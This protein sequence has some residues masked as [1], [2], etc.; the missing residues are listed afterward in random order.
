MAKKERTKPS[1]F[2]R[3]NE[4]YFY[5]SYRKQSEAAG[6]NLSVTQYLANFVK[7]FVILFVGLFLIFPSWV[8]ALIWALICTIFMMNE[9]S[10]NSK[11][12]SYDSFVLS[13]L[14]NYTQ[15]MSLLLKTNNVYNSLV[16]VLSFVSDPIKSDLEE[17]VKRID[18]GKSVKEAF[19]PFNEK[20][21]YRI[22]T[23]YNKTLSLIDNQGD[24]RSENM[25]YLISQE[26]GSLRIKKDR[27]LRFKKEWRTQFY[28]VLVLCMVLPVMLKYMIPDIYIGYMT[29]M[30]NYIMFGVILVNMYVI[31]KVEEIYRN[32]DIGDGGAR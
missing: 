15:Q 5:E 6:R 17:V 26:L 29:E 7:Y 19:I 11:K 3:L 9:I 23:L 10:L 27:F 8:Y 16:A 2:Q 14:C 22:V 25:L 4:K 21:N 13:E 18:Q 28:I 32:Q 1:F 20:Y 31:R 12:M 30:G 24:S